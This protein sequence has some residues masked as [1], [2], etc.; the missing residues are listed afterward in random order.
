[1]GQEH[2]K[3][4]TLGRQPKPDTRLDE[5]GFEVRAKEIILIKWQGLLKLSLDCT[6]VLKPTT[7]QYNC[8]SPAWPCLFLLLIATGFF[9]YSLQ[10]I[11]Q[12]RDPVPL[13]KRSSVGERNSRFPSFHGALP[14]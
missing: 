8:L 4:D 1:M 7:A 13:L 12:S 2:A 11:V 3:E 9:T 6:P 10:L 14:L 5:L